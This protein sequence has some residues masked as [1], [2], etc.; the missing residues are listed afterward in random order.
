MQDIVRK[1]RESGKP[2]PATTEQMAA[3]A[4]DNRLWAPHRSRLI[5]LCANQLADAMRE[6]YITDPQG[7]RVRA[8]H[9]ARRKVGDKQ[10]YFWDD[11]RTANHNH[12]QVATQQRRQQIVGDCVQLKRDVDSYNE[13]R[14]PPIPIQIELDFTADVAEAEALRE[15]NVA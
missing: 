14:R 2:W 8:K 6:E 11:I 10:L 12:M 15:D 4:M 7:R 3:W 9:V 1:Y 13:N 5:R